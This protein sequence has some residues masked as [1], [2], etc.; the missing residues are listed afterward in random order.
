MDIAVNK[1]A[2]YNYEILEQFEAGIVLLGT[3]VKSIRAKKISL[4]DSHAVFKGDEL[5]LINARIEPYSHG[6]VFNHEPGRSR[7]LLLHKKE[8][9]RLKG[10]LREK[11]WVLVP[12]KVY[13]KNKKHIK[14]QLGLGKGKKTHDKSQAIKERDLDRDAQR[15]LKNYR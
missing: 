11:G 2:R 13:L 10:K 4:V 12:I 6:N 9:M 5:F 8:I 15:E 3:E 14:V 7:K 1:K